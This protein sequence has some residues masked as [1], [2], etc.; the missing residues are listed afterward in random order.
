MMGNAILESLPSREFLAI[1]RSLEP[2]QLEKNSAVIRSGSRSNSVYFPTTAVISFVGGSG[3]GGSIEVWS[4]GHEGAAGI[5]SL[6]GHADQFSGV[7]QVPGTALRAK[8]SH[9]RRHFEKH[10]AFRAAALGYMEYLLTQISYLGICNN[11][12]ALDQRLSRWLLVMQERVGANT[13]NF[14]QGAIAGVLGTR[15]ATISVAAAE[16]QA[17]GLISYTPGAITIKSRRGLSKVACGCY[18][19]MNPGLR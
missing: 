10:P 14:T 12:H 17:A 16:L 5:A 9:L 1:S 3:T 13:L 7:V 8:V 11:T 2:V 18:K 6:L 19:V 4:V 15:R